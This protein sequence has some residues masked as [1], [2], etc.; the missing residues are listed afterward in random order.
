MALGP[1]Y[2]RRDCLLSPGAAL[3]W[4]HCAGHDVRLELL[5]KHCALL[6]HQAHLMYV[7]TPRH[8]ASNST[9][10]QLLDPNITDHLHLPGPWT[11]S[12]DPRFAL[13]VTMTSLTSHCKE[14]CWPYQ[15]EAVGYT[16]YLQPKRN[17]QRPLEKPGPSRP[18]V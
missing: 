4:G 11:T 12:G 14:L 6:M 13:A 17:D 2:L 1:C 10:F 8:R 7:E 5:Y 15:G 16:E 18:F 3:I 9:S